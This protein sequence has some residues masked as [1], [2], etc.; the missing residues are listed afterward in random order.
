MTNSETSYKSPEELESINT[1]ASE[2]ALLEYAGLD[3]LFPVEEHILNHYFPSAPAHILDLGCGGGRT[4][5]HL[6]NRGYQV[7]AGDIVPGM[8]E[9]TKK[10]LPGVDCRILDATCLD[11]P[12]ETFDVVW[13][14]FNGLDY[15]YPFAS[16]L[17]ALSEIKRV[18]KPGGIFIYSSHNILGRCTRITRPVVQCLIRYHLA[19]LYHSL[20]KPLLQNYWRECNNGNNWLNTY[21]G[22]PSRQISALKKVGFET[23]AIESQYARSKWVITWKDFWPHYVVRKPE[24]SVKP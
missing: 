1:F 11:L 3:E 24:I 8:V 13:F 23:V 18:L 17:S 16:R 6:V 21:C 4:T 5:A 7:T 14:S 2:E 19:F 10:R 12:S 22:I 20:R 15:I 9:A